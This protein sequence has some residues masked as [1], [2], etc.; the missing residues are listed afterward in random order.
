MLRLLYGIDLITG[1][2][3]TARINRVSGG[4]QGEREVRLSSWPAWEKYKVLSALGYDSTL[5]EGPYLPICLRVANS[6]LPDVRSILDGLGIG[7]REETW[8]LLIKTKPRK[9][10]HLSKECLYAQRDHHDHGKIRAKRLQYNYRVRDTLGQTSRT[11]I[12]RNTI[13]AMSV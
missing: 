11:Y 9:V 2:P 4:M 5:P 12:E 1:Y 8:R 13:F 7:I 3:V 6:W 10:R